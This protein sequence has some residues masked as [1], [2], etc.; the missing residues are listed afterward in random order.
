MQL[1]A[2]SAVMTAR[3]LLLSTLTGMVL[4]P[5]PAGALHNGMELVPSMGWSNWE[6]AGCNIN[7][8]LIRRSADALVA[9]GLA[10]AG[11]KTVGVD[12]CWAELGRNATGHL[13]ANTTLFPSGMRALGDFLHERG[14]KFRI[15]SS[16]GVHTCQQNMSGSLGHEWLDAQTFA[17]ERDGSGWRAVIAQ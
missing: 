9:K 1:P 7:E 3:V 10:A 12:D 13:V 5:R 11:Y 8:D 6:S 17:G 2:S 16:A 4:L 14:L 15:Y